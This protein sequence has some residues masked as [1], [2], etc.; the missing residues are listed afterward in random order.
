MSWYWIT[1]II[2]LIILILDSPTRLEKTGLIFSTITYTV[3]L[4][5]V[6]FGFTILLTSFFG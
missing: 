1:A 2:A 6:I 4:V 3:V 5:L